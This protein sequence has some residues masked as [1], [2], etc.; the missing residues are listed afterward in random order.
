MAG[1]MLI[2]SKFAFM[3]SLEIVRAQTIADGSSFKW[4][5]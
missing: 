4:K 5:Q 1:N 2:G 3:L